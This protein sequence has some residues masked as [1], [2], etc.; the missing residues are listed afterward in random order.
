M[1]SPHS[2]RSSINTRSAGSCTGRLRTL[3]GAEHGVLDCVPGAALWACS[4][5]GYGR[6]TDADNKGEQGRV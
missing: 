4:D 3:V 2:I 5:S 1:P 6:C